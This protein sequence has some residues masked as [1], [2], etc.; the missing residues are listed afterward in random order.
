[1]AM[2]LIW[3][4]NADTIKKK[5]KADGLHKAHL[6]QLT[7]KYHIIPLMRKIII[8]ILIKTIKINDMKFIVL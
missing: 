2:L 8:Q 7:N 1:M 4:T 6:I 5:W 3:E